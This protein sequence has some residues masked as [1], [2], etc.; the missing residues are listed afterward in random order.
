M[1]ILRVGLQ[2]M[3]GL[4]TMLVIEARRALLAYV[5]NG[6][7]TGPWIGVQRGF[8]AISMTIRSLR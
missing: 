8:D 6:F 1:A 3:V 7:G 2:G 4:A 5:S